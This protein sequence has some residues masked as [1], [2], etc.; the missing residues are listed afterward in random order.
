MPWP[1]WAAVHR[2][3]RDFDSYAVLEAGQ[4]AQA[5]SDLQEGALAE[6]FFVL[7]YPSAYQPPPFN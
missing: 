5:E 3:L 6:P 1:S 7:L 2:E 4:P